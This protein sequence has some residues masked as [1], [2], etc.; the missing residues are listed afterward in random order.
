MYIFLYFIFVTEN[1]FTI[2]EPYGSQIIILLNQLLK[3]SI[4]KLVFKG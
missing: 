1:N 3:I 2:L 4:V